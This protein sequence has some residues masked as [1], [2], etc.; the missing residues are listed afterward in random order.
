[1]SE[2]KNNIENITPIMEEFISE[3]N[4]SDNFDFSFCKI[5]E[6]ENDSFDG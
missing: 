6:E 1:M 4:D 5:K 3:N 2:E